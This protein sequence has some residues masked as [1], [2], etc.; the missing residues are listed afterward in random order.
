MFALLS[1]GTKEAGVFVQVLKVSLKQIGLIKS[2][3]FSPLH[4][5]VTRIDPGLSTGTG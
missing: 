3:L 2:F 4:S 5:P 1:P